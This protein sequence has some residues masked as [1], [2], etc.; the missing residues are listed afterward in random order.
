MLPVVR[1]P[2]TST[3]PSE[4]QTPPALPACAN[5]DADGPLLSS[6]GCSNVF[7]IRGSAATVRGA[8][9]REGSGLMV[10]A[11]GEEF[12]QRGVFGAHGMHR[13]A[14]GG[15]GAGFYAGLAFG[16]TR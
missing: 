15:G 5:L 12:H 2:Q 16:F 3:T 6:T 10:S 4:N 14:I 13:L 7:G 1:P 11:E 9:A 8:P